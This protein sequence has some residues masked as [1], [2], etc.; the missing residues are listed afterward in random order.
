MQGH[1]YFSNDHSCQRN[2]VCS[3]NG[4]AKLFK[5]TNEIEKKNRD[6]KTALPNYSLMVNKW[7]RNLRKDTE[8]IFFKI[9]NRNLECR[10]PGEREGRGVEATGKAQNPNLITDLGNGLFFIPTQGW[11]RR[12]LS[13]LAPSLCHLQRESETLAHTRPTLPSYENAYE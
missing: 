5:I 7:C 4:I 2:S 9:Q 8:T 12:A 6:M 1:T 3:S 10:T 11:G 13:R